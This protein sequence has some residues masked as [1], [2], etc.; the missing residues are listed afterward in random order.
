MKKRKER[1]EFNEDN[2]MSEEKPK[3]IKIEPQ[4]AQDQSIL[5]LPVELMQQI[6]AEIDLDQ[7]GSTEIILVFVIG[8]NTNF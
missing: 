5:S 1:D 2:I 3:R 7:L 8:F 6:C 4:N